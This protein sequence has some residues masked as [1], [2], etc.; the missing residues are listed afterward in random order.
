MLEVLRSGN[1][2]LEASGREVNYWW[3]LVIPFALAL[4]PAWAPLLQCRK[5]AK[6]L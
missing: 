4:W 5:A 2:G 1:P 6:R 3:M